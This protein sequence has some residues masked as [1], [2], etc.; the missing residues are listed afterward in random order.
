MA[1][2]VTV[3]NVPRKI[4]WE[5]PEDDI[6]S[7]DGTRDF[8]S[9]QRAQKVSIEPSVTERVM[10][11]SVSNIPRKIE[12]EQPED[13]I[14]PVEETLDGLSSEQIS[15]ASVIE[16]EPIVAASTTAPATPRKIDW[17]QP[18]DDIPSMEDVMEVMA[19]EQISEA[20]LLQPTTEDIEPPRSIV[21]AKKIEWAQP[22]DD[23]PSM[24]D[25]MEVM[26]TEQIV[27]NALVQP[28]A[29]DVPAASP[30]TLPTTNEWMQPEH[31]IPSM[32]EGLEVLSMEPS[33]EVPK[34]QA[35]AKEVAVEG[36]YNEPASEI[37]NVMPVVRP[38]PE[39]ITL[40]SPPR[41]I[42]IDWEQ[43]KP[44]ETMSKE[45]EFFPTLLGDVDTNRK[46]DAQDE[47]FFSDYYTD[48]EARTSDHYR[49]L[50][51]G[52]G[53]IALIV[54]F[55]FGND[56]VWNYL[57]NGS[58]ADSVAVKTTSTTQT[59]P[60]SGQTTTP[61]DLRLLKSFEKPK[62]DDLES[63]QSKPSAVRVSTSSS[64]ETSTA[65]KALDPNKEPQK[66]ASGRSVG[67]SPVVPSTLVISSDDGKISSKLE[68]QSKRSSE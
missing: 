20:A 63:G 49:S 65:S 35:D 33:A 58:P 48:G 21:A 14:P 28:V 5:Q 34:V 56:S 59:F 54:L 42:T 26:A 8:A 60:Q 57:Q 55:L 17:V 51:I 9:E 2:P 6:P 31:D 39:E 13:D 15:V 64:D 46:T 18:D 62:L 29:A 53:F 27:E 24:E 47:P 43:P 7:A 52:S 32:E 40:V 36:S 11:A 45:I 19:T 30:I 38:E 61:N 68:P 41:R 16:Q 50:M 1:P 37:I 10:A 44:W 22:D 23:I 66:A 25:V 3:S 12:W 67:K 4:E